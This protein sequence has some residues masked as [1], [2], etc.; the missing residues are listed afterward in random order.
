MKLVDRAGAHAKLFKN[1]SPTGPQAMMS[2]IVAREVFAVA[3]D[4]RLTPLPDE[5]WPISA[6]EVPTPLGTMPGDRPFLLGGLDVILGGRVFA[7]EGAREM[8]V[9]VEVG[10]TFR[11]RI[12]VFG[13][14]TWVRAEG[15]LVPGEPKRFTSIALSPD[16][17]FG[18][19]AESPAGSAP[20]AE[21]PLG[22]G[23]HLDEKSAEGASL[24]NLEDPA[25]LLVRW[26]DRPLPV[27]VGYYPSDGSLRPIAALDH[28][29]LD[30]ARL[31]IGGAVRDAAEERRKETK[32]LV[33]PDQLGPALFNQAHPAWVIPAEKAP[34][35]GDAVRVSHGR[36][37]GTDLVFTMPAPSFHVHVQ[38][39]EREHVVPLH[40]DQI[41]ILCGEARVMLSHRV[42]F[43]YSVVRGERR[44]ATLHRGPAPASI[45]AHYGADQRAERETDWWTPPARKRG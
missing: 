21:N 29:A 12:R 20:W 15:T 18:G 45:P 43:E 13:D 30:D 3:A 19:S 10:R 14:R 24:P 41:G 25:Q 5:K 32:S 26:S 11:R 23:Y 36:R 4:G 44:R 37:D 9:E 16:R 8:D 31:R 40:L 38:L 22:R 28:P 2:C 1:I 6:S 7:P 27:G 33:T 34:R 35:P 39:E 42:V 17:T